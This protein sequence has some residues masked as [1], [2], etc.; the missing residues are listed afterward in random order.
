VA[1]TDP[2]R[3]DLQECFGSFLAEI[4]KNEAAPSE[5]TGDTRIFRVESRCLSQLIE[6]AARLRLDAEAPQLMAALRQL[7]RESYS[8]EMGPWIFAEAF[9]GQYLRAAERAR[10]LAAEY[11]ARFGVSLQQHLSEIE[12]ARRRRAESG[13]GASESSAA[14]K[15]GSASLLAQP[16]LYVQAYW[17]RRLITD[18]PLSA[19]T[20]GDRDDAPGVLLLSIGN[21]PLDMRDNS[22]V[23]CIAQKVSVRVAWSGESPGYPLNLSIG[24]LDP[25]SRNTR[26]MR[27][28]DFSP[29]EIAPGTKDDRE[30]AIALQYKESVRCVFPLTNGSCEADRWLLTQYAVLGSCITFTVQVRHSTGLHQQTFELYV[31]DQ[32]DD[33]FGIREPN[34]RLPI[35]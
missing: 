19:I 27:S 23:Q 25:S 28:L 24:W 4:S 32:C 8:T 2:R 31:D 1:L 29:I 17:D 26:L 22:L 5:P 13:E 34:M 6:L 9:D 3:A 33:H 20:T 30:F 14:A 21:F 10:T 15:T 16:S 11:L 18:K 12:D 7:R 35:S